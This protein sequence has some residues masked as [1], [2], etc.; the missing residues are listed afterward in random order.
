VAWAVRIQYDVV[1]Q[2][3]ESVAMGKGDSGKYRANHA[4]A[5]VQSDLISESQRSASRKL[6]QNSTSFPYAIGESMV[7]FHRSRVFGLTEI[8]ELQ[9]RH[10]RQ[11]PWPWRHHCG[12]AQCTKLH[13]IQ[14]WQ[15]KCSQWCGRVKNPTNWH[16]VLFHQFR[17]RQQGP[18]A[19]FFTPISPPWTAMLS[20]V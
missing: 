11:T 2:S 15:Q 19:Y 3:E 9:H 7:R 13:E 18:V 8:H 16:H 20:L 6:R 14:P 17:S 5:L 12:I 4:G 10:C 1:R